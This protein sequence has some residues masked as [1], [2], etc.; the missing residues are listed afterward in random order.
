MFESRHSDH[1]HPAVR[2]PLVAC[3]CPGSGPGHGRRFILS[4][5]PPCRARAAVAT[6]AAGCSCRRREAVPDAQYGDRSVSARRRPAHSRGAV[7]RA[8]Y[9]GLAGASDR[10]WAISRRRT[11]RETATMAGDRTR[12]V[13]RRDVLK[14]GSALTA[15]GAVG[16]YAPAVIGQAKPLQGVTLN[17]SCWSAP[18]PELLADYLPEFEEQTGAKVNYDTP[19]FPVYNQRVDLEL[20][21]RGT[22]T[23]CSTSPSSIPAAG[24]A[25]AGSTPLDDYIG[26]PEQD[27]RRLGRRR[28]PAGRGRAPRPARTASSTA[29]PG[30]RTPTWP[31]PA[32]FDLIE[33]AGLGMPDT[34]DD[35]VAGAAGGQQQGR[36]RR[37]RHR[38]PLRL[39][40]H[41]LPAGLRRQRVPQSARRPDADAGHARGHRRGR[42]LR[43]PA[44]GVRARRRALLH[45]RPGR[46]QALQAGPRQ[47]LDHN[48]TYLVQLG[49]AATSKIAST[50]NYSAGAA[51]ARPGA[52]R[53]S[54]C[55]AGASRPARR[56]RTPPGN[57]SS[58]RCR[59]ETHAQRAGREGLRLADPALDHRQ[60][61]SSSSR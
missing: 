57:S 61:P 48:Q 52:S 39:D 19:S 13:T 44:A 38:E 12:P 22:P 10:Q 30:P 46:S 47:L 60:R 27:A 8:S 11:N 37:L 55:T 36:R 26:R 54:P 25:P 1:Y 50:V 2:G 21:T 43:P 56:T 17:V 4:L 29:C 20:S 51:R 15:A 34:F 31:A 32:R 35:I 16:L 14:T 45:L 28:L 53:A 59:K 40:L 7:C 6:R 24:S 33:P 23:T 3:P 58:G 49:D 41:P 18:Y 9:C 5:A 42:V